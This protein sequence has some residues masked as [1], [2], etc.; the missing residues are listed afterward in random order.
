[1]DL[2]SEKILGVL[3]VCISVLSG[4]TGYVLKE[5]KDRYSAGIKTGRHSESFRVIKRSVD[6]LNNRVAELELLFSKQ[7]ASVRFCQTHNAEH[8]RELQEA[9][10]KQNDDLVKRILEGV[11]ALL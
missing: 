7:E 10:A 8:I 1:M 3:G 11:R 5:F 2:F 4:V 6:N 9:L